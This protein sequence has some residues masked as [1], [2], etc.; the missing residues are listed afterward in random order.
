MLDIDE[1]GLDVTDR[2]I[3]TTLYYK[4]AAKPVGLNTLAASISEDS[5]T[6]EEVYE[7]FLLR[8]GLIERTPKGRTVTQMAI[9]HIMDQN[10]QI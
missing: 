1:R 10:Y 8:S 5:N 3:L 4:F 6:V 7:P 9:E 2:K